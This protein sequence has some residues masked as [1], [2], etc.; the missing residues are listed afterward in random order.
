MFEFK[1]DKLGKVKVVNVTE[2]RGSI[3]SIMGDKESN[4][5]ITKNNRPVR[6][7]VD[8]DFFRQVNSSSRSQKPAESK[9]PVKGLL[10]SK[11]EE[12]KKQME[13]AQKRRPDLFPSYFQFPDQVEEPPP[14]E[15]PIIPSPIEERPVA[16][17]VAVEA[18][19]PQLIDEA[20]PPDVVQEEVAEFPSGQVVPEGIVSQETAPQETVPEP[21]V[22]T[23]PPRSDY[24]DSY[25]KL[26]ETPRYE[27]LFQSGHS[28][29]GQIGTSNNGTSHSEA[30]RGAASH[31]VASHSVVKPISSEQRQPVSTITT[32]E[33]VERK[34]DLPSIQDLLSE[35]EKISLS[36]EEELKAS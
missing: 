17:E 14:A 36:D 27:P 4:Y 29:A 10:Q 19:A 13:A 7:V 31:S 34:S 12:L 15:A 9:D 1:D 22:R 30:S 33:I 20:Q 11:T 6:V 35:I 21:E 18:E 2:A 5:V 23:P 16:E 8:Y 32:A 28:V 26:Y 3:A 24:F 25:R